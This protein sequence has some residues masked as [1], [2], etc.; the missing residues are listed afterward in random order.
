M[1]LQGTHKV[2]KIITVIIVS[3]LLLRDLVLCTGISPAWKR[4]MEGNALWSQKR[5]NIL[6]VPIFCN[7]STV[8]PLLCPLAV[9]S[10]CEHRH[11]LN[12][13]PEL[14]WVM[15]NTSTMLMLQLQPQV[16]KSKA[17]TILWKASSP[18]LW[19]L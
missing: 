17:G 12:G 7:N 16:L 14:L 9:F 5:K 3:L 18:G 8:L 6:W 10:V 11:K 19:V 13:Y 15:S 4:C 2:Q 1:L